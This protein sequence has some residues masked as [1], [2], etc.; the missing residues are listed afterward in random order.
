MLRQ[1][2]QFRST[3]PL[4]PARTPTTTRAAPPPSPPPSATA[5]R[6]PTPAWPPRIC[7][8]NAQKP[9]QEPPQLLQRLQECSP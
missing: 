4:T 9:T 5:P 1:C 2:G 6:T 3:L 8:E 7:M